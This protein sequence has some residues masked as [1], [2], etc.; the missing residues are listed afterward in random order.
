LWEHQQLIKKW[1]VS[2]VP[3]GAG[4]DSSA[5]ASELDYAK[6]LLQVSCI[7]QGQ[8]LIEAIATLNYVIF[9]SLLY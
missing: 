3:S 9:L 4:K 1:Q 5:R 7:Y 2:V 6:V 8:G